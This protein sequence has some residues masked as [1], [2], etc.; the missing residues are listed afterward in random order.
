MLGNRDGNACE[1]R[2]LKA[3]QAQAVLH[4][5]STALFQI[6]KTYSFV[7]CNFMLKSG[8]EDYYLV[9]NT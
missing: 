4:T 7:L 9:A 2:A 8:G 5:L 6:F 3:A 1:G